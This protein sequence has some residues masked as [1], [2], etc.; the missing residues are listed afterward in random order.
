MGE[1]VK[2]KQDEPFPTDILLMN[3]SHKSGLCYVD[4]MNLDGETNLKTKSCLKETK[5]LTGDQVLNIQGMIKCDGPNEY[6]EVWDGTLQSF[7]LKNKVI[8][9]DIKQF[10]LCGTIL[11]NTEY[12]MGYIIY[13]GHSTKAMKNSRKAP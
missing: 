6:L 10:L 8:S 13:T 2:I 7:L 1:L 4:T 9:C 3:T 5:N 12:I 11:R